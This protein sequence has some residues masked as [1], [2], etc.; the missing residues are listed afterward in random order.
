MAD[1]YTHFTDDYTTVQR[2][3]HVPSVT[4]HGQALILDEWSAEPLFFTAGVHP[5]V[6]G[7]ESIREICTMAQSKGTGLLF[8]WQPV[9]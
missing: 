3:C 8:L 4:T 7:R 2:S 6:E 9:C 5:H 1:Y